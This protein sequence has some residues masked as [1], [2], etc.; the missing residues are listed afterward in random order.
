MLRSVTLGIAM[1]VLVAA[2]ALTEQPPPLGTVQTQARV[3]NTA[4]IPVELAVKLATGVLPGAVEPAS[5]PANGTAMVTFYLPVSGDWW[6]TV[7]NSDMYPASDVRD[8]G[9]GCVTLDMEVSANGAGGLG[10]LDTR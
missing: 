10:C 7:N 1:P 5:L 9:R 2:C 4:Q 8:I 3:H 6:I